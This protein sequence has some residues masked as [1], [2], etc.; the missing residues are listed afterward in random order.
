MVLSHSMFQKFLAESNLIFQNYEKCH[1]NDFIANND[2][3]KYCDSVSCEYIIERLNSSSKAP[4]T[5]RC[6][7]VHNFEF[8]GV[9]LD[10]ENGQ[11][12]E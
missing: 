4:V 8:I 5:C 7:K 9:D 1:V 11:W 10:F 2:N 12:L 6:G 3:I